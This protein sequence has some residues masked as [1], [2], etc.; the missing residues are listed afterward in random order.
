MRD[1]AH[2]PSPCPCQLRSTP[3]HL[4]ALRGHTDACLLLL[5]A[6]ADPG[7]RDGEGKTP[8]DLARDEGHA[9]VEELLRGMVGGQGS[10]G[11]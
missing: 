10:G 2:L 4:A 8:L 3:L 5:D 6:G 9:V 11:Y 1:T 7:A